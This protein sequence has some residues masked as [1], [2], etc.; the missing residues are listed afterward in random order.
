MAITAVVFDVDGVLIRP[1]EFAKVLERE[2]AL[3]LAATA[4]F[5]QGPFVDC[6]LG[7]ADL[8]EAV[9]PFLREWQWRG[10]V[11][12][13]L[14]IWFEADS[15]LNADVLGLVTA[16]RETGVPCYIGS[17]QE[18]LRAAYLE[19][20]LGF[21][22]MF[23]DRFFSCRVRAMKP[24]A[25]FFTHVATSVGASGDALLFIDDMESNITGARRCGWNAE[26]YSWGDDLRGRLRDRGLVCV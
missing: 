5:F 6:L 13:F 26:L 18:K 4:G 1:G 24:D 11:E 8:K 7:R 20:I 2:Y 3:D 16:L 19:D 15:V 14:R 25:A 23:E 21:R 17:T 12:D 22:D 10:S 9:E